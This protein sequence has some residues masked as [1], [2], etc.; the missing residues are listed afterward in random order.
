MPLSASAVPRAPHTPRATVR[1]VARD[2]RI[3][4]AFSLS[5]FYRTVTIL[6]SYGAFFKRDAGD[7]L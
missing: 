2:L 3:A 7:F 1:S 4:L 5:L 6:C